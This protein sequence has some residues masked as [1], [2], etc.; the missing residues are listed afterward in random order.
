M[1]KKPEMIVTALGIRAK[2]IEI[3]HKN[4]C[5]KIKPKELIDKKTW[6]E[7]NDVLRIQDFRWFGDGKES[8]WIKAK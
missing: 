8:C 1:K 6:L 3:I 5:V 4:G 2:R 7:I